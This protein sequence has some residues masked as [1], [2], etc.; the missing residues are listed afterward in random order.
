MQDRYGQGHIVTQ[1]ENKNP[2]SQYYAK[3]DPT[4][5]SSWGPVLD[6]SMQKAWNGDT[7][8]FSK[9]GNKLKDYF[10]TGF[11]QNHNVSVSNVTDKSHFR[12]SFGSSNNKGV[13]PNEK[14]NRINLDLNAGMEMNN[15][16]LWTERFHF[17]VP[18]QKIVLTSVL[19]EQSLN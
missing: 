1:D 5:S 16:S 17:H 12:A 4:D 18:K 6:G 7:Y 13:F 10:D 11:A 15:I 8:A 9:Y 14:L 19:T 2:L 3:Y